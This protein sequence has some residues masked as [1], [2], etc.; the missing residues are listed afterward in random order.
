MTT[1]GYAHVSTARQATDGDSLD[2][3]RQQIEG[4][5]M[6]RGLTLHEV[7]VE[8]GVS[9]SVPVTERPVAGPLF[10]RLEA[11]DIVITAKLDRMFRSGRQTKRAVSHHRS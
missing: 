11:G 7:M 6:M 10:A 3:Q 5:A 8:E 1:Y 9:G 4:Y 2:V